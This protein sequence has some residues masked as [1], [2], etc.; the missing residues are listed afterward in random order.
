MEQRESL[1]GTRSSRT[2]IGMS[3]LLVATAGG[4][5]LTHHKPLTATTVSI[6]TQFAAVAVFAMAAV[7]APMTPYARWA[8]WLSGV[9]LAGW[10][11]AS[12]WLAG[13][14]QAWRIEAQPQL[15]FMPWYLLTASTMPE[16]ATGACATRGFR[17]GWM[18]VGGSFVLGGVLMLAGKIAGA[19]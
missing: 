19:L 11:L 6:A 4:V 15:W 8:H 5:M 12:P 7:M 16:R 17:A 9:V 1:H 3:I 14:P 18:L 13:S 10:V 2:W